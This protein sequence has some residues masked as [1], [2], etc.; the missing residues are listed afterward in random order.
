MKILH[1]G[2]LILPGMSKSM[3]FFLIT[4]T[5]LGLTNSVA[6]PVDWLFRSLA[7]WGGVLFFFAVAQ[8]QL[9][10]YWQ[11]SLLYIIATSAAVQST[12]GLIQI[13]ANPLPTWLPQ[14]SGAAVG[15]F[16]QANLSAS[17]AAT[18]LLVAVYLFTVPS[19]K[20][21]SWIEKSLLLLAIGLCT[22]TIT[23]TG[24]RVALIS[25][26]VGILIILACR[27]KQIRNDFKIFVAIITVIL[28]S[29]FFSSMLETSTGGLQAG[30]KKFNTM[31]DGS[32]MPDKT[33]QP[34]LGSVRYMIYDSTIDLFLEKPFFGHGIGQFERVWH[35]KKIDYTKQ[36]PDAEVMAVRLGHPHN[37]LL[38][39]AVEGGLIALSGILAIIGTFLWCCRKLGWKR[40]GA[41]VAMTF[42]I[43]LHTQL[44]LPF[45]ISQLHWILFIFLVAIVANHRSRSIKIGISSSLRGLGLA[46]ALAFPLMG[47]IFFTHCLLSL[48]STIQFLFHK[49]RDVKILELA[50]HNLYFNQKVSL[51]QM[52]LVLQYGLQENDHGL[53]LKYETMAKEYL[54]FTPDTAVFRGL[55][56]ALHRMERFDESHQVL[57]R[58]VSMYPTTKN[59]LELQSQIMQ[60]DKNL[61]IFDKFWKLEPVPNPN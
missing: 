5:V 21:R 6:T 2:V 22:S 58:L 17:Y 29:A 39:W 1:K 38:Y 36:H 46:T 48:H 49:N 10:R 8:F 15:I 7:I 47:S 30:F 16:Q 9:N 13:L 55:I 60:L 32:G 59:V 24:S 54:K 27:H 44:E 53:L 18:G 19:A 25:V 52:Q 11:E 57:H 14:T 51:I 20:L 43:T 41:Y 61:G 23:T 42:P 31:V 26:L 28:T 40:G 50:S 34:S 4:T 37:E 45:Y 12:Y 35:N 3:L 56:L 33:G